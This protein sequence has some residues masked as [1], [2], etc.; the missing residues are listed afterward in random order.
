MRQ[1]TAETLFG[2]LMAN[3]ELCDHIAHEARRRCGRNRETYE[4]LIQEVWCYLSV[5]TANMPTDSYKDIATSVILACYRLEKKERT[6]MFATY[7]ER[8]TLEWSN[9]NPNLQRVG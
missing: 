9:W 1:P 6:D 8:G 5:S 4:D 7:T 2:R 3:R